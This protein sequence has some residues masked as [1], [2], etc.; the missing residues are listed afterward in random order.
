MKNEI[1][2]MIFDL[3]GV[4]TDT[5]KYHYFAWKRIS[6]ELGLY[7]D[8]RMN[9]ALKGIDR[10]ESLNIILKKNNRDVSYEEKENITRSKNKYYLEY[11]RE[12]TSDDLFPGVPGL[13]D[14]IKSRGMKM[15]LA[16]SSKNSMLIIDKLKI[17]DYFDA[18]VDPNQIKTGKPDPEIFIAAAGLLS[19]DCGLCAV[20]EDSEAGL[21]GAR[22]AGMLGIGIGKKRVLYTYDLIYSNIAEVD[23]DEVLSCLK[24][25]DTF[26]VKSQ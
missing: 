24:D 11:I 5:A 3:D 7:F 6:N 2:G 8:E 16:S 9:E 17:S 12:M 10:F 14:T 4:I 1:K 22:R 26:K 25:R 20:V 23:M 13:F 18:I 15:A 21:I 19:V